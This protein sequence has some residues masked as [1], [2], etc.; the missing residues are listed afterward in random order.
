MVAK[1]QGV[2]RSTFS[3]LYQDNPLKAQR[4]CRFA[5]SPFSK[6]EYFGNDTPGTNI[7]KEE[8]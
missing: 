5:F 1:R 2:V 8:G 4:P 7:G 6:G 3:S